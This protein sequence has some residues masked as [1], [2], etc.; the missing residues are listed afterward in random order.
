MGATIWVL[1]EPSEELDIS[2]FII[3]RL[4]WKASQITTDWKLANPPTG[5]TRKRTKGTTGLTSVPGNIMKQN[6]LR[7]IMQHVQNIQGIRP[8]QQGLMKGRLCLA[9]LIFHGSVTSLV[10]ERKAVIAVYL[11]LTSI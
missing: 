4:S 7:A 2:L 6:N 10:D 3:C 8:N 11:D 9:N 5:K 1:R